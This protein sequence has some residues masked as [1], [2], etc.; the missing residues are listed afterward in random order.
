MP[1]GQHN[2]SKGPKF[3]EKDS[4]IEYQK[5]D[6]QK[7]KKLL[8]HWN[9]LIGLSSFQMA[10][11]ISILCYSRSIP[12]APA[13]LVFL[14]NRLRQASFPEAFI[15]ENPTICFLGSRVKLK[16]LVYKELSWS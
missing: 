2:F 1:Y 14:F 10:P 12:R 13:R 9:E 3:K 4:K 8:V 11:G 15:N 6:L 16:E 5:P 7:K